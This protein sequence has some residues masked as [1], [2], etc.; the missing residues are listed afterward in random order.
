MAEVA[1]SLT[2]ALATYVGNATTITTAVVATNAVPLV[3]A[4]PSVSRRQLLQTSGNTQQATV[5]F[6]LAFISAPT[7][8]DAAVIAAVQSAVASAVS[9]TVTTTVAAVG[10]GAYSVT[11]LFPPN[12]QVCFACLHCG[13]HE[14]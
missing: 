9:L 13:L 3:A 6:T 10:G 1:A 14:R 7:Q 2:Q 5:L 4:S 11:V 8:S 12:N